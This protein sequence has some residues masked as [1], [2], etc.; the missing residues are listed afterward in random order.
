MDVL[1]L[2]AS[3]HGMQPVGAGVVVGEAYPVAVMES[4]AARSEV[5]GTVEGLLPPQRPGF[6]NDAGIVAAAAAGASAGTEPPLHA[7]I[8]ARK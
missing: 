5:A 3:Q 1:C 7:V 2:T 4:A 6:L 8:T